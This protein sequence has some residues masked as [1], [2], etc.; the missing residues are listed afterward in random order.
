LNTS[1]NIKILIIIKLWT[2]E[3]SLPLYFNLRTLQ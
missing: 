2:V 1:K 3:S